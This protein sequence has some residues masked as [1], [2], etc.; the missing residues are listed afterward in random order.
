MDF[1]V[2]DVVWLKSAAMS[3][4]SEYQK[5]ILCV[6]PKMTIDTVLANGKVKCIWWNGSQYLEAEFTAETLVKV[7][8]V[9]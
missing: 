8:N 7:E 5:E 1:K 4:F 6:A 3:S 9:S 2:G